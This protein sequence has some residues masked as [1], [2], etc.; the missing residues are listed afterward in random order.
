M[1]PAIIALII[2]E[3]P[4]LAAD[5]IALFKKHPALTPET[6]AALAQPIYATNADTRAT[7]A[8]DQAANPVP[9]Q[10]PTQ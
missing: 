4:V 2:Q 9:G 8:T 5:I 7:V 6:L 3:A 1:N 10:P